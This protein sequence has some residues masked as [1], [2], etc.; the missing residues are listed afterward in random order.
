[1]PYWQQAALEIERCAAPGL[2]AA[3]SLFTGAEMR[4]Q[5]PAQTGDSGLHLPERG[6]LD[7]FG[8]I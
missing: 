4:E 8:S 3:A 1:M 6:S 7:I 2:A 5:K